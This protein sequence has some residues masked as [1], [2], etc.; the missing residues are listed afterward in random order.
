MSLRQE[1]LDKIEEPELFAW[2]P[3]ELEELQLEAAR[4]AFAER[5]EQIPVLARLARENQ[6]TEVKNFHDLVPLLFS[7]TTYKSYPASFVEQKRWTHLLKWLDTLSVASVADIDIAGVDT[8]DDWISRL[9]DAGHKVLAT[10]GSSGKVSFLNQSVRDRE[11]KK[12][13]FK[14]TV[15][16]P[17]LKPNQ[18]RAFFSIGPHIG[19]NSA[20]EASNIQAEIWGKPGEI[21][22]LTDEPLLIAEVSRTAALR[23][24]MADG[25]AAPDEIE[26]FETD[27]KEKAA[28]M[29]K[30]LEQMAAKIIEH[31][32]E[33][34]FLAALWAQHMM[35]IERAR[36]MGVDDGDFHPGSVVAAGGGVKGVAL[37]PD[38]K[39]IVKRFYG[40]VQ[41]PLGY[42]MTEMAQ[43][44]P[45][46]EHKRYHRPPGLI[47]LPLDQIGETLLT[48]DHAVD[49]VVE[50]RFAFLDLLF[51]GRWGGLISG[52]KVQVDFRPCP[53]GR[54]GPTILDTIT[55][56]ARPG[57]EDHIGCAGT[58]D[59]YVRGALQS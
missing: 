15:G 57:E 28:R 50:G 25:S 24:R 42:G 20:I 39:E 37:P 2:D 32:H 5:K 19:F 55:R 44:M 10:S 38:Y 40:D 54:P 35:I 27:A 13:H 31:R 52:D 9:H 36:A 48:K 30:A 14:N 17:S 4:E 7:H 59:S 41:R 46:C 21:H 1:L 29:N 18:D 23:K 58:I 3:D 33:P 56:F 47:M 51:D 45:A 12:R 6:I 49:G 34:V 22:F 53:C 8:V 11:L 26:E 43:R 16:W